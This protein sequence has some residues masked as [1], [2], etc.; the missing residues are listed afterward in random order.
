MVGLNVSSRPFDLVLA[1]LVEHLHSCEALVQLTFDLFFLFFFKFR[2]F[3]FHSG[4]IKR[5]KTSNCLKS[6][7]QWQDRSQQDHEH[8][9]EFL[10]RTR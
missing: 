7:I 6:C 4:Q 3:L 2:M 1:E 5:T 10:L 8:V 9:T